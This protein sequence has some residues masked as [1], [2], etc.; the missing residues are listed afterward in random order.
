M[1]L[2]DTVYLSLKKGKNEL[3]IA[4]SENFGGW[5]IMAAFENMAG[6]KID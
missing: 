4:V 6:I 5:G 3:W 2:Y 1:G